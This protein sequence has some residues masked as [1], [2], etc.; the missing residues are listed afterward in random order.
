MQQL[1]RSLLRIEPILKGKFASNSST[2]SIF[3]RISGVLL[4]TIVLFFYLLCLK[5]GLIGCFFSWV[6]KVGLILGGRALSFVLLKLGC[7]GGLTLWIVLPL[8]ALLTPEAAP[9]LGNLMLPNGADVG[10]SSSAGG[11]TEAPLS[12]SDLAK[13]VNTSSTD[14]SQIIYRAPSPGGPVEILEIPESPS[15]HVPSSP[16]PSQPVPPLPAPSGPSS[17]SSWTEDSFEIGVLL[18]PFSETDIEDT[19]G[20]PP[21]R[22]NDSLEAS[23]KK[24]IEQLHRENCVFLLDKSQTTYWND[25]KRTLDQAPFQKEYTR[26]LDF[27][28][29]DLQIR[30]LKHSC[31]SQ[32][33]QVLSARPALAENAAYHPEE[34]LLDF[35]DE[36]RGELDTHLEWSIAKK[37]REELLFLG[38]V[39]QDIKKNGPDSIYM[40][41]ILG[42]GNE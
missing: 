9:Y 24:R 30:E 31:F 34:A 27:E 40:K 36:K 15:N 2:F 8:R 41:K 29:R 23:L 33:Q 17:S 1:F 38:K 13:P 7:S 6:S 26:L 22:Q 18:E 11:V 42:L 35:F 32:F 3:N 21:I 12:I 10:A 14:P 39:D 4:V 5:I 28:N 19:S 25:I 16:G 20:N 37:D